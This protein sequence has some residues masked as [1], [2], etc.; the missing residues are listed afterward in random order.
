MAIWT[1]LSSNTI[2]CCDMR[3]FCQGQGRN[4]INNI[5][6]CNFLLSFVDVVLTFLLIS[7]TC[8]FW[9]VAFSFCLSA[10]V[11][12]AYVLCTHM[13]LLPILHKQDSCNL[14]LKGIKTGKYKV[15][16]KLYVKQIEIMKF[17]QL[18]ALLHCF[19]L[20]PFHFFC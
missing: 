2:C 19:S 13:H 16:V 3:C 20:Q 7:R 4:G 8:D 11:F 9:A 18:S 17:W 12:A 14:Q 10:N 15:Y 1:S 6:Q 5:V